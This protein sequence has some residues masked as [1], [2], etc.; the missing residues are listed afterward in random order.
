MYQK[1]ELR[2]AGFGF[3]VTPTVCL[4]SLP[5]PAHNAARRTNLTVFV[6]SVVTTVAARF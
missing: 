6:R 3:D 1:E 4:L 2:N 5:N